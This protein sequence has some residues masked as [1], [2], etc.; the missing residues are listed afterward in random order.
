MKK[1]RYATVAEVTKQVRS[2]A[3]SQGSGSRVHTHDYTAP[4]LRPWLQE[5]DEKKGVCRPLGT[6]WDEKTKKE[7]L[8]SWK[9]VGIQVSETIDKNQ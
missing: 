3:V 5:E 7:K 2:V 4:N 1:L 6:L 8:G 9:S